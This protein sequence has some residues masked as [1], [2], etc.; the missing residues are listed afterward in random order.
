MIKTQTNSHWSVRIDTSFDPD[1]EAL[2][3]ALDAILQ[4]SLESARP[5]FS[6][7][8][9]EEGIGEIKALELLAPL[10]IGHARRLNAE[11][12][13]AHMD[14]PTPWVTW[15]TS[16]WNAAL[17]QNLLHPDVAPAARDIEDLVVR[18][19][20]PCFG[21]NGGHMTP[22]STVANLTA[23]WA[24]REIKGIRRVVSSTASHLSV[25]K[26][27]HIL[28][29]DY[30]AVDTTGF[31]QIDREQLPADLSDSAI[32]LTAGTT[33]A[34]ALD[35]LTLT[36]NAA[37]KHVDAAWA[38][39]LR[40]SSKHRGRLN[41]IDTADSIAMSAHKWFFQPKESGLVLFRDSA[42]AHRAVSFGGAYLA[43]PNIGVM[44]SRS[45]NAVP[46][47]A[48]LLSW[49]RAGL[50]MRINGAMESAQMLFDYLDKQANVRLYGPNASGVILWRTK[51]NTD[52]RDLIDRLPEGSASTTTIGD[53]GWVRHVAA[54]P[55]VNI[56]ALQRAIGTAISVR[57]PG[58]DQLLIRPSPSRR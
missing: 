52:V 24:A 45:A 37:W 6:A 3:K 51:D 20:A 44:G 8:L 34:G 35:D 2:H 31:G 39:P 1:R 19:L 21:M 18:W 32:V 25:A 28:G 17:N 49:G 11:T 41:G 47:F 15:A 10:V 27:A 55:T 46:L 5:E 29:L 53:L 9:P 48:T 12:A 13:F 57:Q 14:P 16:L 36:G 50:E 56:D 26:S 38:G 43:S 42:A 40:L 33:S 30:L 7:I 58:H 4:P 23:L 54:N 22:G